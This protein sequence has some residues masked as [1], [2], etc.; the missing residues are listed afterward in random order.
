MQPPL[1]GVIFDLDGTLVDSG[2]DFDA[3]RREMGIEPGH[4]IL[5]A[6]AEISEP[7]LSHCL[8]IVDRHERAGAQR[9]T[10]F[11]GARELLAAIEALG[12][13]WG[14]LTR[15][16]RQVTRLTLS[17][18]DI[19]S[20]HVIARE[21]AAAKPDSAGVWAL[22]AKWRLSPPQVVVIGDYK[23]DLLAARGAGARGVLFTQGRPLE[24]FPFADLADFVVHSL[25]E[26]QLLIARL[27]A[28]VDPSSH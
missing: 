26:A 18:L 27:V 19:D 14:I 9:A 21:D 10:L 4:T 2:L 23:Y 25:A 16:S 1:R 28:P 12:L 13:P 3:M 17:R 11:D 15:N 8:A 5:E 7:R 20:Q 6:L 24:D 22:C